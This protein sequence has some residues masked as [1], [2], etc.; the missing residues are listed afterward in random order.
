MSTAGLRRVGLSKARFIDRFEKL[1]G[2]SSWLQNGNHAKGCRGH[3]SLESN[4]Q[5]V[6][7]SKASVQDRPRAGR[8][9]RF[10]FTA[11]IPV[12]AGRT[13]DRYALW[14]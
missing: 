11:A 6:R 1:N 2:V 10:R 5:G 7:L 13:K 14:G 9:P 4:G 12:I 3:C 8:R